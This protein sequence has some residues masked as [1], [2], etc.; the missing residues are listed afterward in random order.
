MQENPIIFMCKNSSCPDKKYLIMNKIKKRRV[1]KYITNVA[2][3]VTGH[4][5]F[6]VKLFQSVIKRL[7]A[8]LCLILP[9]FLL[10]TRPITPPSFLMNPTTNDCR[11]NSEAEY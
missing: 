5:Q 10:Q 2:E 7:Y 6:A 11:V 8:M 9:L 1:E 4:Q 3:D